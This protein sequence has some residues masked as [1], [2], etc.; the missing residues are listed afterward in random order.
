MD[1]EGTNLRRISYTGTYNDG[2][3]WSPD[4][5][6]VAYA[7]RLRG[8]LFDIVVTDLAGLGNRTLTNGP[9][10]NESPTWSPDGR[11]IAYASAQGGHTQIR[12][13]RAD[14]SGPS[15]LLTA[16]G[17]NWSPDWSSYPV[18]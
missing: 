6:Q 9:G 10:S 8:H 1:V 14:G 18:Q 11:F 7:S 3:A 5:K 16:T 12:L 2:A 4:G 13:V 15:E 17:N